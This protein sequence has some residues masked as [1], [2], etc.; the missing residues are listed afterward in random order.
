MSRHVSKGVTVHSKTQDVIDLEPIST[1]VITEYRMP[2]GRLAQWLFKFDPKGGSGV[3]WH[4]LGLWLRV[5]L[6][7]GHGRSP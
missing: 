6:P 7:Y 5:R 3:S 2:F 4:G 1:R